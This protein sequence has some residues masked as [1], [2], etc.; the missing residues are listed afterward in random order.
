MASLIIPGDKSITISNRKCCEIKRNESIFVEDIHGSIKKSYLFFNIDSI[1]ANAL[2]S[3]AELVLFKNCC[4]MQVNSLINVYPLKDDFSI[5][6]TYKIQPSIYEAYKKVGEV[7]INKISVEVDIIEIVKAWFDGTLINK[8]LS[9][10]GDARIT[11]LLSFGST[12]TSDKYLMPIL[13]VVYSCPCCNS[14][15]DDGK[16]AYLPV[17]INYAD[18]ENPANYDDK[19]RLLIAIVVTVGSKKYHISK[20][21]SYIPSQGTDV[22]NVAYIPQEGIIPIVEIGASYHHI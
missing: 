12:F 6:T 3:L 21:Y 14:Q 5:C 7:S 4:N 19:C 10:E 18:Y 9:I 8:G 16:S 15:C 22:I 17:T 20:E 1:P 2:I 11:P 13:R